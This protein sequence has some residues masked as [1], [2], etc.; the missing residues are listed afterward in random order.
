MQSALPLST[1]A[2]TRSIPMSRAVFGCFSTEEAELCLAKYAYHVVAAIDQLNRNPTIR[3]RA[4]L[5]AL[6]A[7]QAMKVPLS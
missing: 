2:T 6:A 3:I 4:I 5:I 1:F 7:L